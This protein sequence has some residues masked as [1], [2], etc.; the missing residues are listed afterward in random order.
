MTSTAQSTSTSGGDLC[1]AFLTAMA[2]LGKRWNA[3][4]IQ[5][6]AADA[7]AETA[8]PEGHAVRFV[9]IRGRIPGIRDGVLARRLVELTDAGLVT[10][11]ADARRYTLTD[12]GEALV[13]VLDDLTAWAERW[14][15]EPAGVGTQPATA[16][17]SSTLSTRQEQQ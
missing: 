7:P 8:A 4:I 11:C 3:L 14:L 10:R 9:D 12:R 17:P 16:T 5:A 13:P 15:A 2:V 6:M 1:P